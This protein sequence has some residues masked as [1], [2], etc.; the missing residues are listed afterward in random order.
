MIPW[1]GRGQFT[2]LTPEELKDKCENYGRVNAVG[3]MNNGVT[4]VA[5]IPFLLVPTLSTS[6]V[7]PF[8]PV[9]F[10]VQL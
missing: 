4:D 6:Q 8:R 2:G 5:Q 3:E 10:R 7:L 1:T 9:L